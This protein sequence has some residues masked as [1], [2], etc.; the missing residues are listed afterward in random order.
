MKVL[1]VREQWIHTHF[2]LD[3]GD[4]DP[5]ERTVIAEAIRPV[6]RDHSIQYDFYFLEQPNKG[7]SRLVL[8]CV[9]LDTV[10]DALKK[11]L[12]EVVGPF[13]GGGERNTVRSVRVGG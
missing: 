9:P 3:R 13:P 2:I 1:D 6:L 5:A 12:S 10:R 11:R 7:V 8:E 4:V